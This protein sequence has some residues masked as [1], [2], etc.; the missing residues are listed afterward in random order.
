MLLLGDAPWVVR[1]R[2]C[3]AVVQ[4]E[5]MGLP[6]GSPTFVMDDGAPEVRLDFLECDDGLAVH[7]DRSR[8]MSS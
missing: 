6:I 3:A 1:F 7:F 4:G 8:R 5:E 2:G